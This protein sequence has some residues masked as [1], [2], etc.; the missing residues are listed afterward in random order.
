MMRKVFEEQM[1]LGEVDISK[2]Q[3]DPRSRDEMPQLLKGL[4]FIYTTP[5]L[6]KQ[7]F[8]LLEAHIGCSN[9]GRRGMDLWKILVLGAVRLSSNINYDRLH[10]LANHHCKIREMLG[11]TAWDQEPVFPIQ[12]IK[13]NAMLLTP[14]LL[15][16]INTIVVTA[17]HK[18]VK[19]KRRK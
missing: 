8:N 4:Q 18:L 16:Q 14:E 11:I 15:D 12:T 19:K 9:K 6:R 10:D 7:V 13:D 1:M 17:G 3:F 2:V 5:E